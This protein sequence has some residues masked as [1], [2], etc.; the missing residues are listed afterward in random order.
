[1]VYLP[2]GDD[3]I[4]CIMTKPD[5]VNIYNQTLINIC[6]IAKCFKQIWAI[7]KKCVENGVFFLID[8]NDI[9]LC[10]LGNILILFNSKQT[11]EAGRALKYQYDHLI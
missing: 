10:K 5:A 3:N 9:S 8:K 4:S 1:M 2:Q 6:P 11:K 7:L